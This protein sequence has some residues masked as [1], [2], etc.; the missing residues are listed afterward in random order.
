[1]S[2]EGKNLTVKCAAVVHSLVAKDHLRKIL[3]IF[4]LLENCNFL[5]KKVETFQ[6]GIHFMLAK[7]IRITRCASQHFRAVFLVNDHNFL[8]GRPTRE[9][10]KGKSE[11]AMG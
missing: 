1:M 3:L 5:S 10:E 6:L 9:A 7:I 4:A 8:T 2:Q 11:V